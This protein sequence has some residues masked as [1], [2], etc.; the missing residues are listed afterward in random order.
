MIVES[1]DVEQD[2]DACWL[3]YRTEGAG[4]QLVR[5]DVEEAGRVLMSYSDTGY[6]TVR[7]GEESVRA[8]EVAVFRM[9]E[10]YRI[11]PNE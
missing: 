3:G 5:L 9:D 2:D 1:V 7:K 11:L 6:I 10:M 8:V 4:W